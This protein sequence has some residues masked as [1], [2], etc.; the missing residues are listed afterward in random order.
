MSPTLRPAALLA[1]LT[2]TTLALAEQADATKETT[3]P[4]SFF[5]LLLGLLAV[6]LG[7]RNLRTLRSQRMIPPRPR[8]RPDADTDTPATK[9]DD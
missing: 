8:R 3:E 5:L 7:M 4:A 9:D 1:L 6:L 2:G